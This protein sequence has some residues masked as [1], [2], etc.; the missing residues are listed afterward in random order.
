M[1]YKLDYIGGDFPDYYQVDGPRPDA[2][3]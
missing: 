3:R 2:G 1:R